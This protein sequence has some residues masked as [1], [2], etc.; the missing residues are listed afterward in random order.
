MKD[1]R[2][3]SDKVTIRLTLEELAF[4]SGALV[5]GVAD[6]LKFK[7]APDGYRPS[8]LLPGAKSVIV[9]GGAKPKSGD[10]AATDFRHMELSS[11]NDRI[12]GLCMRLSNLIERKFGYYAVT[13]P[14]GVDEGQ[15]PFLNISLAAELAGCGTSSLAGPI[16]SP[17]HGFVYLGALITTLEP[18]TLKLIK[19]TSLL[20]L[21]L[22]NSLTAFFDVSKGLKSVSIL[23]APD[24]AFAA[25]AGQS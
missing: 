7:A 23:T 3:K 8:D 10:W 22:S 2:E 11:T 18:D 6:A 15:K 9:L 17:K 5:F 25:V 24:T 4:N 21:L 12:T 19:P 14:P 1:I 16:L 20:S 13:V